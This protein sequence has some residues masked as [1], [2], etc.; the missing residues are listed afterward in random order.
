MDGNFLEAI[1]RIVLF[2]FQAFLNTI[3]GGKVHIF[4]CSVYLKC[5]IQYFDIFWLP[6]FLCDALAYSWLSWVSHGISFSSV[7]SSL[8]PSHIPVVPTMKRYKSLKLHQVDR[9]DG[10]PWKLSSSLP[11]DNI[12][13][14]S[15]SSWK[16]AKRSHRTAAPNILEN[17][18]EKSLPPSILVLSQFLVYF[19]SIWYKTAKRI[20]YWLVTLSKSIFQECGSVTHDNRPQRAHYTNSNSNV[21]GKPKIRP[22]HH[23]CS[24]LWTSMDHRLIPKQQPIKWPYKLWSTFH[25]L[26]VEILD[27]L[28]CSP[29]LKRTHCDPPL[30]PKILFLHSCC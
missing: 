9:E 20:S 8:S 30:P 16:K 26:T 28:A 15:F 29:I 10:H 22:I 1:D 17:W 21:T 13:L 25:S 6:F 19:M 27:L 23:S 3:C 14:P 2:S 4:S 7:S 5:H 12:E 24:P 11:I 18:R